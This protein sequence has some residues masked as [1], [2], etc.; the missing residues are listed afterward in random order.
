MFGSE[1]KRLERLEEERRRIEDAARREREKIEAERAQRASRGQS[2]LHRFEYLD[3]KLNEREER[4][5]VK[6]VEKAQKREAKNIRKEKNRKYWWL[7]LVLIALIA[8]C[9]A[10]YLLNGH[11]NNRANYE[12]A[13]DL[14][15]AKDY[16]AA[17]MVL[18]DMKY[19]DSEKI[20][21]Y[22]QLRTGMESYSGKLDEYLTALQELESFENK[23]INSQYSD[24]VKKVKPACQ[25]QA[26]INAINID[27]LDLAQKN[28]IEKLNTQVEEIGD[29]YGELL[30]TRKLQ[31]AQVKIAALEEATE[32]LKNKQEQ[33]A[34]E[35][36]QAETEA[37]PALEETEDEY[38]TDATDAP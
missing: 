19:K 25:L 5:G 38:D 3:G 23:D 1:R 6:R 31:E 36:Q 16:A 32:Q 24:Y 20:D 37:D 4:R 2:S 22:L 21:T 33:D 18:E 29:K 35:A 30:N 7:L 34:R 27:E 17:E 12:I 13:T 14:V 8:G 10:G 11:F 26:K 15:V 28:K 9:I